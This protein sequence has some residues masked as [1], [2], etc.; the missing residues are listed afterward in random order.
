MNEKTMAV[1]IA[2]AERFLDLAR[3]LHDHIKK[4]GQLIVGTAQ[5]G[6]VRRASMDL[7]RSLANVRKST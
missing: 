6:A 3:P 4:N 2:D 5:S 7:T 1:A